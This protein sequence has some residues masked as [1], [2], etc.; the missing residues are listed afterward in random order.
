MTT[1]KR[2]HGLGCLIIASLIFLG[3][4]I[5]VN[6]LANGQ[7]RQH[8]AAERL[9]KWTIVVFSSGFIATGL[10]MLALAVPVRYAQQ[11]T[12][13]LRVNNPDR[14]WMWRS[15]W[16]S[17]HISDQTGSEAASLWIITLLFVC[18]TLPGTFSIYQIWAHRH[19]AVDLVGLVVPAICIFFAVLATRSTLQ[20]FRFGK[21]VFELHTL[22]AMVG[23]SLKGTIRIDRPINFPNGVFLRLACFRSTRIKADGHVIQTVVWDSEQ[24]IERISATALTTDIPVFFGIPSDTPPC[25]DYGPGN[26]VLWRLECRSATAHIHY[27]IGFVV[28]V[29]PAGVVPAPE[30]T[31]E[32][33]L[34]PTAP[35]MKAPTR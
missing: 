33:T 11:R 13:E 23:N 5:G 12:A 25:G 9:P 10:A 24:M 14:A 4:G 3:I 15:D 26:Q 6:F 18:L 34:P 17:A 35:A 21:A 28:P 27:R 7:D 31:P 22:P 30:Q 16:A 29:F 19:R 20:R 2:Q 1:D 8:P 32:I